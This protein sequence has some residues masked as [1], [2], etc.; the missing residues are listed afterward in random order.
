MQRD[1]GQSVDWFDQLFLVSA[2]EVKDLQT[3]PEV[4]LSLLCRRWAETTLKLVPWWL[5]QMAH[6]Q[7]ANAAIREA[8]YSNNPDLVG[9]E[10]LVGDVAA[11]FESENPELPRYLLFP[12]I[13]ERARGQVASFREG[14]LS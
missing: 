3:S 12:L 13:A 5:Q 7:A 4:V 1:Q 2:E 6:E 8:F 10:A 14:P 9:H 11:A